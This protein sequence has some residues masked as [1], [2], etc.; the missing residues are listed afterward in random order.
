MNKVSP[1]KLTVLDRLEHTNDMAFHLTDIVNSLIN[2]LSPYISPGPENSEPKD[3]S[4]GLMCS[5]AVDGKIDAIN[6]NIAIARNQ[7]YYILD[8][9]VL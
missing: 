6:S 1:P 4:S 2:K 7:L 5:T 3:N 8:N 9:M